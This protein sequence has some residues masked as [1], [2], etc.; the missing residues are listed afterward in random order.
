MAR[1]KPYAAGDDAAQLT[2]AFL[3]FWPTLFLLE[4]GNGA[5]GEEYAD[6]K[7]EAIALRK[8]SFKGNCNLSVQ[9]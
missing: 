8:E 9:E 3:I 5:G 2:V 6:L 7:G 1:Y 4:G